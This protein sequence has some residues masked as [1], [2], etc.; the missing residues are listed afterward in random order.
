MEKRGSEWGERRARG[1]GTGAR[2]LRKGEAK[3]I[4]RI[5]HAYFTVADG[6]RGRKCFE[7]SFNR[8]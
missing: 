7:Q 4:F 2:R 5:Y 8:V 1:V 6:G 3:K